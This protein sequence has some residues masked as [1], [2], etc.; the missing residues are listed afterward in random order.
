MGTRVFT[1]SGQLKLFHGKPYR[2]NYKDVCFTVKDLVRNGDAWDRGVK[3]IV[4]YPDSDL[5]SVLKPNGF[6]NQIQDLVEC[7]RWEDNKIKVDGK[8]YDNEGY[9]LNDAEEAETDQLLLDSSCESSECE[10]GGKLKA[11]D[12]VAQ[13]A[14]DYLWLISIVEFMGE[15]QQSSSLSYDSIA[16]MMIA[17]A[18]EMLNV[19]PELRVHERMLS[20]CIEFLIEES[21]EYMNEEL[22]WSSSK[23]DVFDAIKDYP[24]AGIF[25]DT[26]EELVESAPYNV[27]KA[28]IKSE[29]KQELI[30]QSNDYKNA[31]LYAIHT[32]KIDP[33]IEINPVW[34]NYLLLDCADIIKYLIEHLTAFY[35]G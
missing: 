19:H 8:W 34:T 27:L 20:G 7:Q 3:Q 13:N 6:I 22:A 30:V 24:M 26:V 21:K 32:R 11:L 33:Y 23:D 16:C 9:Y 14:Y 17:N 35:R 10:L 1:I 12:K 28:W 29:D 5:F 25:E 2:F 4:A 18:W 15:K 31:C